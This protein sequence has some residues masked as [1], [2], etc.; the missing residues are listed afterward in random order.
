MVPEFGI[1]FPFSFSDSD[2]VNNGCLS[3]LRSVF[4]SSGKCVKACRRDCV[5]ISETTVQCLVESEAH[6]LRQLHAVYEHHLVVV[7]Q[8][9]VR[10]F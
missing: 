9:R 8:M 1:K 5:E 2:C 7:F 10:F 6:F 4:L 3:F